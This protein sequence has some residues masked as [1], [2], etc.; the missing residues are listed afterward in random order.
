[1][2]FIHIW[3]FLRQIC[4]FNKSINRFIK[5]FFLFSKSNNFSSVDDEDAPTTSNPI[6]KSLLMEVHVFF[7]VIKFLAGTINYFVVPT[8]VLKDMN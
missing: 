3:R 7:L 4:L 2:V 6:L 1:M 5:F 8:T